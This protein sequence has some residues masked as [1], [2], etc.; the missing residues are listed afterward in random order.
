MALRASR[1]LLICI[2][3]ATVIAVFTAC[4]SIPVYSHYEHTPGTGWEKND[5]LN[6]GISP[7]REA[8]YYHEELGLRINDDFPFQGLCLVIHQTILPSGYQHSDTLNCSL[9]DKDG[10]VK[11]S[12][13]KHYQYNFH[14]NTIRLDEGDSLHIQVKHNMKREI[15][16][17]ITD[18][19]I[20][21]DKQ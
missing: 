5:M 2:L 13:I 12:G 20:Q 18:I 6:F 11:G 16:P 3:T 21:V 14:V 9:I 19:G 1:K 7:V 15:M 10:V 17:G 4:D 8:G